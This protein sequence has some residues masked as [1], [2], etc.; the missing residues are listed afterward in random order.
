MKVTEKFVSIQGEGPSAG[1]PASF[2]RLA[3]C[4]LRC[5]FCD[6]KYAWE[7]G[8]EET[9]DDLVLWVMRQKPRLVVITGGEPLLQLEEV[10]QMVLRLT[11]QKQFEIEIET[12]GLR[13]LPSE[14]DVEWRVSPKL[15]AIDRYRKIH[16]DCWKESIPFLILKFVVSGKKEVEKVA[17]LVDANRFDY[18]YVYLMPQAATRKE[19]LERAPL[20]SEL[21]VEYGFKFSPRLQIIHWDTE[22]GR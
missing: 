15:W 4:D 17:R 11:S 10:A 6:S 16:W 21:C 5:G 1:V 12:N 2:V 13:V 8:T 19:Y 7:S 3:G 9:V 20:I 22:R 14:W 18:E